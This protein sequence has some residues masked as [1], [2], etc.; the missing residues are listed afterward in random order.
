MRGLRAPRLGSVGAIAGLASVD[1]RARPRPGAATESCDREL[2]QRV[3][4]RRLIGKAAAFEAAYCRFESCRPSQSVA[5]ARTIG[6]P[7][8]SLRIEWLAAERV[9]RPALGHTRGIQSR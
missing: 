2:R 5:P 6:G 8:A 4:G 7:G 3:L 9:S 1:R